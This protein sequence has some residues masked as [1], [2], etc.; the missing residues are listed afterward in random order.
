MA[1]WSEGAIP[2]EVSSWAA[3]IAALL[4]CPPLIRDSSGVSVEGWREETRNGG[5]TSNNVSG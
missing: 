1:S 5:G 3:L 2:L 4:K